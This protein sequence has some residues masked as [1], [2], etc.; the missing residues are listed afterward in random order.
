M[1]ARPFT[2]DRYVDLLDAA[3][4]GGYTFRGFLDGEPQPGDLFLR[5]DVDMSLS[6]ALIMAELEHQRGVSATYFLMT[7]SVFYNLASPVGRAALDR[8]QALGHTVGHHGVWPTANPTVAVEFAPVLAWHTPEQH[9]MSEPVTGWTNVMDP[10]FTDNFAMTYRSDSNQHWRRGDPLDDLRNGRF[11]WLQ[12]LIHP[13][14]WVFDGATI[15]ETMD[16]FL[17]ED[18]RE[19]R[20]RLL[21]ERIELDDS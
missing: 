1:S 12:L 14:L 21:E 16:A 4:A 9:Y 13:E 11:P 20:L 8:L 7:E 6:A 2:L 17:D 15:T 10:C 19:R 5:H 3:H 18:R